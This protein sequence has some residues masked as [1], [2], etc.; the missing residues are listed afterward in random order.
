MNTPT[1]RLASLDV[2]RGAVLFLLVFLQPVVCAWL[3]PS[4]SAV[5]QAVCHQLDHAAWQGFR[6]WDLVMPLFLFM[7]GTSLPFS[8]GKQRAQGMSLRQIYG[9]LLRRFVLLFVLGMVVQGNLLGFDPQ[10]VYLYTNTLQAIAV[11]YVVAAVIVLHVPLCWQWVPCAV[12]LAAYA[13]PMMLLGDYTPEGNVA[14]RIDAAVLGRFRG[15]PSYAWLLPSLTFGVTVL[16]G[17]WAGALIRRG[18][19][20]PRRTVVQLLAVGAACTAAG[21]L[22]SLDMPIIKRLWTGSMTLFAGGLCL[23]LM[24]LCYWWVDV[25]GRQRGLMWLKVYGM[26]SIAAYMLGEVVNFRSVAHSVSYG[27]APLLGD[28]Y[29]AWLTLCNFTLLYYILRYMYRS[30]IFLKV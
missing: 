16:M 29:A 27:L 4:T 2:L 25:C 1:Q 19:E 13:L 22:W 30:G 12:L 9:K 28:H 24:A 17:S 11:G 3:A 5:A 23:M 21:L 10:A 6:F 20:Q 8:L 7:S 26:N 15:D 14:S 18:K